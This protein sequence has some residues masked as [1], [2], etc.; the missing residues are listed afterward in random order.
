MIRSENTN[1]IDEK[2]YGCIKSLFFLSAFHCV[3]EIN[4]LAKNISYGCLETIVLYFWYFFWY[5]GGILVLVSNGKINDLC[6]GL[7][8]A[9]LIF[10]TIIALLNVSSAYKEIKKILRRDNNNN[11]AN[12]PQEILINNV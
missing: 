10:Y 12:D 1:D 8:L 4:S 3:V 9:H 6:T 7:I 11:N 5:I 2:V